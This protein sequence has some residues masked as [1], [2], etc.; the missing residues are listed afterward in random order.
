M[1]DKANYPLSYKLAFNMLCVEKNL[2]EFMHLSGFL[3]LLNVSPEGF[4]CFVF[5]GLC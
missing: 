4:F 2:K 5:F 1:Q 3:Q